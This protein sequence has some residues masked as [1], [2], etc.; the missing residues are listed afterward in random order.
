MSKHKGKKAK[1]ESNAQKARRAQRKKQ[2][3]GSSKLIPAIVVIL[4]LGIGGFFAWPHITPAP[5]VVQPN[6]ETDLDPAVDALLTKLVT[7]A[8]QNP[9]EATTHA[10]LALAYEANGLWN[11]AQESYTQA[12]KLN[13]EERDWHL[14]KAVVARQNGD[15][16]T[17]LATLKKHAPKHPQYAPL[18]NHY[19]DALLEAGEIEEAEKAFRNLITIAPGAAQGYVGL[20]DILIQQGNGEEAVENLEEAVRKSPNYKQAHYLLGRAY[21]L[22]GKTEE[23]E[24]SLAKGSGAE[25]EYMLDPLY[26]QMEQY[27]VN[28]TG[29]INLASKYLNSGNPQRAAQLL[30]ETYSYHNTNVMLLNTLASAYLR[31]QRLDDAR[32][33]LDRAKGLDEDQFFTYLNLYS[34]A[35]R[36][37]KKDE[38]LGFAQQAVSHAPDRDD[39]HL[40]V[41]QSLTEM[42]RLEEALV[43]AQKAVEIDGSKG[44]NVGMLGDILLRL[45]RY[46]DAEVF[47]QRA[48]AI[49][50]NLLPAIVGLAQ[51]KWEL[52]DYEAARNLLRRAQQIAPNHP[53]VREIANKFNAG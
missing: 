26:Q 15:F 14:H 35:L 10:A 53:R 33:L 48:I 13:S 19:A 36:A 45:E 7:S 40:A 34:W 11:E 9:R 49:D 22:V 31:T 12:I 38:A 44:N 42:N 1:N 3:K 2:K 43:S 20:G 21:T 46:Q 37:Q 24:I 27:T 50:A 30:E 16:D 41:A 25:I 4:A 17:A 51:T 23:A 52:G 47:L 8:E 18:Q 6:V 28:A 32:R 5:T 39:T 29:R